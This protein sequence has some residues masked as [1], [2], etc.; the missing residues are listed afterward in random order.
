MSTAAIALTL[1]A[2]TCAAFGSAVTL[3]IL[4]SVLA[5]APVFFFSIACGVAANFASEAAR[6]D[7][8]DGGC[9]S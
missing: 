7:D 1:A 3:A 2:L 6:A 8:D 5:A 9:A 4:V